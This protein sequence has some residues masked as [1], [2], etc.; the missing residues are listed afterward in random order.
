VKCLRNHSTNKIM[1]VPLLGCS[2]SFF[3]QGIALVRKWR[4]ESWNNNV[5]DLTLSMEFHVN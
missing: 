2:M 3:F 1:V 5:M 4:Y